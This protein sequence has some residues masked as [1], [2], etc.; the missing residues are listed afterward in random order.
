MRLA[1]IDNH[2]SF[3]YNLV[4]LL[5]QMEQEVD[6]LRNDEISLP[7]LECYDRLLL[8]P[9]P[10]LPHEAGLLLPLL[11]HYAERKPIL[12]VCLGHQALAVAFGG[13]LAQLPQVLHGICTPCRCTVP[14]ELLFQHLP[15]TFSVGRY[16]SWVVDDASLP[17][18]LEVTA[19]SD[20]GLIMALRH[21]SLPLRSVQFHP[22]SILTPE[23]PSMLRNWLD[24]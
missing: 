10:G 13:E 24:A 7:H 23:G 18:C 17:S 5:R 8:S 14:D 12:G 6:V 3:V 19:R 1:V 20:E 2:D 11:L 4:H 16:H 9:G 15:E 22:E 21:R